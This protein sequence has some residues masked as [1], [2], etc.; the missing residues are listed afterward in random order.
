MIACKTSTLNQ[1]AFATVP[2]ELLINLPALYLSF[3]ESEQIASAPSGLRDDRAL[4]RRERRP[5]RAA[6]PASVERAHFL[7]RESGRGKDVSV[8][9]GD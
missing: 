8:R 6:F 3:L 7:S 4:H 2:A 1:F 5:A 9:G